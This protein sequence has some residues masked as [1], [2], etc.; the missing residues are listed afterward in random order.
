[1]NVENLRQLV[2]LYDGTVFLVPELELR[3]SPRLQ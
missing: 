3:E 2:R 1:M